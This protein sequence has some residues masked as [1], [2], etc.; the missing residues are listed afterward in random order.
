MIA[1]ALHFS[2]F[3]A[4]GRGSFAPIRSRLQVLLTH[5]TKKE[6]CRERECPNVVA[7]YRGNLCFDMGAMLNFGL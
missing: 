2:Q 1:E 6:Y 7:A 5:L 4:A 3:G